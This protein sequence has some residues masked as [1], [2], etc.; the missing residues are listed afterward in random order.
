[1]FLMDKS[2][3]IMLEIIKDENIKNVL[4]ANKIKNNYTSIEMLHCV[5]TIRENVVKTNG[6]EIIKTVK[7]KFNEFDKT[8]LI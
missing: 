5:K 2:R 1:M 4:P 7:K 8:S 6:N 3:Q